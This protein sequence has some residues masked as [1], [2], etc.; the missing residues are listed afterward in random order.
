M[1]IYYVVY[2]RGEV[3]ADCLNAIRCLI[4]P[5]TKHPAHI[6]VRGPYAQEI[7]IGPF[8]KQVSG[9]PLLLNGVGRFINPGQHVVYLSCDAPKLKDIWWKPDYSFVPHLTLYNGTSQ[10]Q[11]DEIFDIA[12]QYTYRLCFKAIRLEPLIIGGEPHRSRRARFDENRISA[13]AKERVSQETIA[14]SSYRQKINAINLLLQHLSRVSDVYP[15]DTIGLNWKN[16]EEF[17]RN[18][19]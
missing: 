18:Q 12:N 14:T 19:T 16:W 4:K 13:I 9:I 6:T 15:H 17:W 2:I 3:V 5:K 10:E 7:D 1:E 8:N 11:A